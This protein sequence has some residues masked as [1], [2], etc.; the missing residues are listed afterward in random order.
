MAS[1]GKR[2]SYSLNSITA[3]A[4]PTHNHTPCPQTDDTWDGVAWQA[5]FATTP[6]SG[7][8]NDSSDGGSGD[9]SSW[10]VVDIPYSAFLPNLRGRVAAGAP[11][12]APAAVRQFGFMLSKFA[13]GGGGVAAFREGPFRL[14]VRAVRVI[15]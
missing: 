6:G 10:Q 2:T 13:A 9:D 8:G 5:D 11:P 15:P 4:K 1:R 14:E 7:G 3:A 12:L